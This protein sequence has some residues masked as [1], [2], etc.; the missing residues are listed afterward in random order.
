MSLIMGL[1]YSGWDMVT[2]LLGSKS[3]FLAALIVC[4]GA[5]KIDIGQCY[6]EVG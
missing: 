3:E 1:G 4:G 2:I 5:K 6:I